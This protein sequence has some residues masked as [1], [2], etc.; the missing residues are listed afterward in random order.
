MA[1]DKLVDSTQLDADLTSV[2]NAI[3]TK[4]GTSGQ[5]AFPNGFVSAVQNI[6][7][8]ITP[9]GTVN[10]T[11][12]GTHDVTNYASANV[13]VPNPST[14]TI[15]ITQNGT[16]NVTDYASASVNV[17]NSYTASD[18]G[19]VVDN[20]ALVAQTSRNVTQNGTY[21]TTTN[22]SVVV[23]VPSVTP[24]GTKQISIT[25]NGTTTEDVTQYANAEITVDVQGL[26]WD[27]IARGRVPDGVIEVN[28][29]SIDASA[30]RYISGSDFVLIGNNVTS[31][32]QSI[33]Q[34]NGRVTKARLPKMNSYVA[35]GYAFYGCGKLSLVDYGVFD[36]VRGNTF[37]NC[38]VLKTLILRR[39]SAPTTLTNTA[40]FSGTPFASGREG[41]TIYIPEVLYNHLG[42]GTALDYKSLANW[43]TIDGYGTITWAKI[44]GSEYEL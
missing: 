12:N 36:T 41:G 35:T 19:K 14:G 34:G 27:D 30:F 25:E 24:T 9:T 4:G 26:T 33:L 15:N 37:N 22:N 2:A 43:S 44:E 38:T 3:R 6:P 20:G 16:H 31:I 29:T 42:D 23:N 11:Q 5:L 13:N 1:V 7:T 28:G 17:P 18:E 8:G 40:T 10:I 32:G 21:D 39:S